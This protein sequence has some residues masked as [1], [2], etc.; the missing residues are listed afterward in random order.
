MEI[1][2]GACSAEPGALLPAGRWQK[3]LCWSSGCSPDSTRKTLKHM[4]NLKHKCISLTAFQDL[5]VCFSEW[6][7]TEACELLTQSWGS[8]S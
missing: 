4:L 5:C 1:S 2:R 6:G 3:V 8:R 7:Q